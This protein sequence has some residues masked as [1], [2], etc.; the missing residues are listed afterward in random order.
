MFFP[1]R[2]QINKSAKILNDLLFV[3]KISTITRIAVNRFYDIKI[4][5]KK[6]SDFLQRCFSRNGALAQYAS[7]VFR[8]RFAGI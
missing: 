1:S 7:F 3:L 2:S 8:T 6:F 4:H 5:N